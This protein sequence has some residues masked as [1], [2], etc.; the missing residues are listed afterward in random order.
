MKKY[1]GGKDW[2]PGLSARETDGMARQ[3]DWKVDCVRKGNFGRSIREDCGDCGGYGQRARVRERGSSRARKRLEG[4]VCP[5]WEGGGWEMTVGGYRVPDLKPEM[6]KMNYQ[7]GRNGQ[8][9]SLK[10]GAE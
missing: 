8:W 1:V 4:R 7:E 6:A 3:S 5:K 9:K 2:E 10:R